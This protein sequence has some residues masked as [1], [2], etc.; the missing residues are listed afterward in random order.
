MLYLNCYYNVAS[1]SVD[2]TNI[3]RHRYIIF[4]SPES[5]R[6]VTLHCDIQPGLL[7]DRYTV[8]WTK[9]SENGLTILTEGI[10]SLTTDVMT[11]DAFYRCRVCIQHKSDGDG[12]TYLGPK[13]IINK[14][15]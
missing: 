14:A 6:T 5:Q 10:Y 11:S 2:Y 8:D 3:L 1:P 4:P 12:T 15:G 9:E 7:A 13:I